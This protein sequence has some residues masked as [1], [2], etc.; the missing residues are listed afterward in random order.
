MHMEEQEQNWRKPRPEDTIWRCQV[1]KVLHYKDTMN[2]IYYHAHR[3][4]KSQ[5]L[6]YFIAMISIKCKLF[7]CY[8]G[9]QS[10]RS[11]SVERE[12]PRLSALKRRV[13]LSR[14][15]CLRC[16][17]SLVFNLSP[18]RGKIV[19]FACHPQGGDFTC[20]LAFGNEVMRPG[21]S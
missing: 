21:K 2:T 12:K 1:R 5:V 14:F 13:R 4:N 7:L 17:G 3:R 9:R 15:T 10:A 20:F 6:C 16:A 8:L 18:R 19:R 11:P